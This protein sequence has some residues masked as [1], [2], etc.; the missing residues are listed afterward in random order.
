MYRDTVYTED[1][2]S[3]RELEDVTCVSQVVPNTVN[4]TSDEEVVP[5]KK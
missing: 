4:V 3:S 2:T 1:V 5:G